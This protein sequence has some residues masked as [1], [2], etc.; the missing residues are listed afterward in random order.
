[1]SS[2]GFTGDN[3]SDNTRVLK[4]TKTSE[5]EAATKHQMEEADEPSTTAEGCQCWPVRHPV[6][7]LKKADCL[8]CKPP[9]RELKTPSVSCHGA[10]CHISIGNAVL[11]DHT[12]TNFLYQELS[13]EAENLSNP[14]VGS[15]R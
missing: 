3:L 13:F 1:M 9:P 15:E 12:S 2:S 14:R 11:S 10:R 5:W 6:T 7:V 4:L 8:L